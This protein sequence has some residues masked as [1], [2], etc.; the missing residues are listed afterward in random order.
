MS[1]EL[2]E[3]ATEQ[4]T[5][6]T[7]EG[8]WSPGGVSLRDEAGRAGGAQWGPLEAA[9]GPVGPVGATSARRGGPAAGR[10]SGAAPLTQPRRAEGIGAAGQGQTGCP[11]GR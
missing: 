10:A 7:L 5:A 8:P 4:R 11:R 2:M 9:R 6:Y 3:R 1:E